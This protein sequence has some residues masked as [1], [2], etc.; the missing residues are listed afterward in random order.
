MI[1][2]QEA[3]RIRE[4]GRPYELIIEYKPYLSKNFVSYEFDIYMDT[5]G[6]HP[7]GFFRTLT[8]D[9]EGREVTLEDLFVSGAPYLPRISVE[10][11]T[12]VLAQLRERSG[13]EVSADMADM[14]RI[15]TSPTPETLQFFVL[16]GSDL[17]ILIPPYQA[18]SYASGTFAVRIP[19]SQL[20]DILK[21]GI[22]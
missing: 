14:V 22:R 6:A 7:N 18:A 5:G 3:Q 21:P 12:E 4:S 11:Y 15:G 19:L 20:S 10:V 17:V 13:G 16:D 1:N 9:K 8:L 2:A